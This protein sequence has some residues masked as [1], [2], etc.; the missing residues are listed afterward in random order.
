VRNVLV[1]VLSFLAGRAAAQDV[2]TSFTLA[3]PT[4][5]CSALLT[6]DGVATGGQGAVCPQGFFGG[7]GMQ[8]E[9]PQD[10]INPGN[11]VSMYVCQVAVVSNTVPAFGKTP[12]PPGSLVQS[13]S[14]T[15]EY[16]YFTTTWSGTLT[17]DY[18]SVKQTHCVGGR[19]AHCVTAYYPVW[20]DGFGTLST[21]PPP[22]PPPPLPQPTVSVLTLDLRA[23]PCTPDFVCQ[24]VPTDPSVV[25]S[26]VL[27]VGNA[28]LVV[29][30]ADGSVRTSSLDSVVTTGTNSDASD[31]PITVTA[32][33]TLYDS[34]GN[35]NQTVDLSL[36]VT[37]SGG[38]QLGVTSGTLVVTTT[39]PPPLSLSLAVGECDASFACTLHPTDPRI[40]ASAVLDLSSWTLTLDY[41]DGSQVS[42]DALSMGLDLND[43]SGTSY[44]LTGSGSIPFESVAFSLVLQVGDNQG[45]SVSGGTLSLTPDGGSI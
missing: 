40:V 6:Q 35:S 19:G 41:A 3:A 20:V 23:A 27:D 25:A 45:L 7:G 10:P 11:S 4:S 32:G 38:G 8:I 43:P 5:N 31:D 18:D 2:S 39:T 36:V 12:S 22:P 17:S 33:G 29:Y 15:V 9:L 30:G 28:S 13:V 24:I 21:P 42:V 1:C 34:N 16:S 14:C 26:A 37:P 44:R